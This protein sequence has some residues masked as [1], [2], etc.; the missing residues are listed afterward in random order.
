VNRARPVILV[1]SFEPFGGSAENPSIEIA[2]LLA[3]MPSSLGSRVF[4]TLP[5]VTG[6]GEGSA[7]SRVEPAIAEHGPDAVIALGENAKADRIHFER[8]AINLRDARIPDN[9]GMQVSDAPV[10]DGAP[11]A[12]FARL[13]LREMH[14]AC[15]S[16]GAASAMS[17]SAGAFLCNELMF[18]LLD[19][20]DPPLAGFIHVP[21][22]PSQAAERGGPSMEATVAARGIHA[23][24]EVLAARIA[25][26]VLA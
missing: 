2:R 6:T 7:W 14:S 17:L 10:V 22:L 24:I 21:Q 26:G 3:S 5:V 18:R 20:G 15:E 12:Y 13:P 25:T 23:A 11:D 9:A 1:T 4:L 19:A 16:A 8:V